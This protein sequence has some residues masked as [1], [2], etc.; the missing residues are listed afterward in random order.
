MWINYYNKDSY[1]ENCK[2]NHYILY[3]DIVAIFFEIQYN[4]VDVF[5]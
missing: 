2:L 1:S 4:L 3:I 5:G